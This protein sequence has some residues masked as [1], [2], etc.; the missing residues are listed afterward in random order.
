MS[1]GYGVEFLD[2]ECIIRDTH[3]NT[4]VVRICMTTHRLFPLDANDV[5]STH[6]VEGVENTS[7][8]WH[9]RFGHLKQ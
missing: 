2:G 5:V 8:L 4:L 6:V 7:E 9:M 3:A 1:S